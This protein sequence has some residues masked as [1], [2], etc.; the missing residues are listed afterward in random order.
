[1]G[2]VAADHG[3]GVGA[4]Q[5]RQ[6]SLDRIKQIAVVEGI[7]QVGDDFGVGLAGKDVAFFL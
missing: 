2:F 7:N 1:M 5:L 3:H 4:V 6:R